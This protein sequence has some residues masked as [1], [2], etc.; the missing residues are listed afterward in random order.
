VCA[1]CAGC[2]GFVRCS[3]FDPDRLTVAQLGRD[4]ELAFLADTH[5]E[6]A[7]VPALDDLSSSN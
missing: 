5:V 3:V 4:G 2:V 6:Q 7:L 1:V